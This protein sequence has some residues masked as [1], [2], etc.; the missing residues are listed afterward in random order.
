MKENI[1]DGV[2]VRVVDEPHTHG[3]MLWFESEYFLHGIYTGDPYLMHQDGG[4]PRC[5]F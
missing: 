4:F 1:S 5:D 2:P 3:S